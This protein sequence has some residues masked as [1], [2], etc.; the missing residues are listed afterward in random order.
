MT[1]QQQK[2]WK[3]LDILDWT[4]NYFKTK[5]IEEARLD[6]EVLLAKVLGMKRLDLYLYFE[7]VI[8]PAERR[9]Y[10]ECVKKRADRI[11]VAYIINEKEFMGLTIKVNSH[12]LIPRPETEIL[13][14]QV[15][16]LLKSNDSAH[17]QIVVDVFTGSG[18][19]P[20]S[21]AKF[22]H[23]IRLYALDISEQALFI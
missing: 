1:V 12:V 6:A 2:I 22:V 5:N 20:V 19:I 9:L 10:K 16:D 3:V 15:I 8:T 13:I 4:T 7:R 23:G 17:E 21:L 18:N 11:P 14:E